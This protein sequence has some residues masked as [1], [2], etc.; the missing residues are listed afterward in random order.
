MP[1]AFTHALVGGALASLGPRAARGVRLGVVLAALSVLPDADVLGLHLGVAYDDALGHRGL[2]HSLAFAALVAPLATALAFRELGA[3]SRAWWGIAAL[4]FLA[5]AS[6][7]MLDALTDAGLGIGF[8]LP[9]AE[10]RYFAP[11]RPLATSPL[12]P[13]AVF[14]GRLLP[15]LASELLWVGLPVLCVWA[16]V[17][18]G[19]RRAAAARTATKR[20]SL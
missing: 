16:A 4:C 5:T 8:L 17:S 13:A 3:F 6:H 9:F 11:W 10:D 18:A 14:S 7:G 12:S 15:V 2:T 20:R 1:T 19:R